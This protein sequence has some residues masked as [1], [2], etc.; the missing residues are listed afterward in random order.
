M[1]IIFIKLSKRSVNHKISSTIYLEKRSHQDLILW[2][3]AP[4]KLLRRQWKR[5]VRLL[6]D[7]LLSLSSFLNQWPQ[8]QRPL[9]FTEMALGIAWCERGQTWTQPA[10]QQ[11]FSLAFIHKL[12]ILS[13]LQ[14]VTERRHWPHSYLDICHLAVVSSPIKKMKRWSR[15]YRACGMSPGD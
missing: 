5:W 14:D 10:A 8:Q 3:P 9:K 1:L 2:A 15:A 11:E 12:G 6:S 13:L 7:S 4:P